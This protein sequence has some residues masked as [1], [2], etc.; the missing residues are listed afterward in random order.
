MSKMKN[1]MDKPVTWGGYFKLCGVSMAL[2]M[3]IT[4][5]SWGYIYREEIGEK[6]KDLRDR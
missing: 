1:F 5:A 2:S 3:V 6:I 4:A